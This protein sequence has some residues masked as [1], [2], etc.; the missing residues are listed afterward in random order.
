MIHF[1]I[2]CKPLFPQ[3]LELSLALLQ[4][5]RMLSPI[6]HGSHLLGI[7]F[8]VIIV[9]LYLHPFMYY[10]VRILRLQSYDYFPNFPRLR[11]IFFIICLLPITF[12]VIEPLAPAYPGPFLTLR[13]VRDSTSSARRRASCSSCGWRRTGNRR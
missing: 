5:K 8:L 12:L 9:Q 6:S 2:F 13:G 4:R 1:I 3:A 10:I 11:L 7:D